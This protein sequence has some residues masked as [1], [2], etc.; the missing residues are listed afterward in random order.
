MKKF[1]LFMALALS[2][3]TGQA[4]GNQNDSIICHISGTVVDRPDSKYAILLEAGK[5]FRTSP[6]IPIPIVD[7]KFAY[8]L[9]DDM[10]RVYN[11][12]FDDDYGKGMW[13][14]R[15]FFTGNGYVEFSC[16]DNKVDKIEP[17]KSDLDDNILYLKI[18]ETLDNR[19]A[20]QLETVN[21]QISPLFDNDSAYTPEVQS[22][23]KQIESTESDEEKDKLKDLFF[24][25]QN[26]PKENLYSKEYLDLEK[27]AYEIIWSRDSLK[28]I[29][30]SDTP[31]LV[32]LHY[33]KTALL[34]NNESW[35]DIPG[36]I[37]LF[38]TLYKDNMKDHPYTKEIIE[39]IEARD[40]KAGNKYPDYKVTREDGSTEQISSLIKGDVAVIDLWASWCSP[41]RRH[42]IELIPLYEKYKDKGF[43]VVAIAR[44]GGDCK[45]MNVAM[46]KDGYPWESFVD[47][48][49]RDK[50]WRINRA[51]NSG[52]KIILVDSNG[53]IVGTDMPI[54]EILEFL[55]KK[56]G[57]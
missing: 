48:N 23:L 12:T 14:T 41:C 43:K 40:V 32:G 53:V 4:A 28:R 11:L 50:V 16:G 18:E 26:G 54:Q 33:I 34:S 45:A 25:Y 6:C 10:P 1:F 3:M 8:T 22:L 49:D 21:A 35:E 5:D 31:N 27:K 56:Y 55:E 38:E 20:N 44:E 42:S 24:Q 37:E 9:K 36:Y 39:M 19:Y 13:K 2:L 46:E 15:S 52:G 51:G 30:I 29:M 7:G 47:L 17:F 57:K